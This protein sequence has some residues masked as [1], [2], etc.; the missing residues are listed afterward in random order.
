MAEVKE[1]EEV[2]EVK[3]VE[4]RSYAPSRIPPTFSKKSET[5]SPT[6]EHRLKPVPLTAESTD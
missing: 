2:K 5:Y 6:S 4:D 1:V 3:E